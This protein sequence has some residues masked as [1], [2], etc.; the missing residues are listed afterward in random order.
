M[1][2][3]GKNILNKLIGGIEEKTAPLREKVKEVA[4]NVSGWFKEKLDIH[5]PSGVFED[6]AKFTFQGYINGADAQKSAVRNTMVQVAQSAISAFDGSD[7]D[8]NSIGTNMISSP[9]K[10]VNAQKTVMAN[11]MK[12]M[13]AVIKDAFGGLDSDFSRIGSNIMNSFMNAMSGFGNSIRSMASGIGNMFSNALSGAIN[14]VMP[15]FGGQSYSYSVPAYEPVGAL[16]D[17][18]MR[19]GG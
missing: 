7:R 5:S 16:P 8:F 9:D 12:G 19:S 2:E 10:A 18:Q 17:M 15:S 3:N 13:V 1:L 11:Q 6:I 4:S 14:F